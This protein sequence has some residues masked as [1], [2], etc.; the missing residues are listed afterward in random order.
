MSV[1][2]W[3]YRLNLLNYASLLK[4]HHFLVVSDLRVV[5]NDRLEKDLKIKNKWH[6]S[7]ITE[8]INNNKFSMEDS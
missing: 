7:R 2:E 1:T 5:D 3:L 8:M 4:K 6:R